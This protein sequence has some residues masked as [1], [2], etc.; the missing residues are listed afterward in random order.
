MHFSNTLLHAF[1]LPP[2][3]SPFFFCF[4]LSLSLFLTRQ[5]RA[6]NW[7]RKNSNTGVEGVTEKEKIYCHVRNLRAMVPGTLSIMSPGLAVA[8]AIRAFMHPTNGV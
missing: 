6:R 8:G 3:S 5:A 2:F 7:K 4:P 1:V